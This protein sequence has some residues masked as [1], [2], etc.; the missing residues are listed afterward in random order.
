MFAQSSRAVT[1]Q[2]PLRDAIF[3]IEPD[4]IVNCLGPENQREVRRMLHL[5]ISV[6]T[7]K[8]LVLESRPD[9]RDKLEE[10]KQV[11][12]NPEEQLAS[13]CHLKLDF[14]DHAKF[15]TPPIPLIRMIRLVTNN[16]SHLEVLPI[17]LDPDVRNFGYDQARKFYVSDDQIDQMRG[18]A[19]R[20]EAQNH[21]KPLLFVV[22]VPSI[23]DRVLKGD[24][25]GKIHLNRD[26][27][28]KQLKNDKSYLLP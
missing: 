8:D 21:V 26:E 10:I 6:L 12:L 17:P 15:T 28:I 22:S 4:S 16:V 5:P 7:F 3:G 13:G 23:D 20:Q 9:L 14:G 19:L 1:W 25:F 11:I 27:F 24:I 18:Y 2:E